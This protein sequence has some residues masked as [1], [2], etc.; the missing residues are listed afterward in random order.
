MDFFWLYFAEI[1]NKE[2][3]LLMSTRHFALLGHVITFYDLFIPSKTKFF[4]GDL[5][6]Y[7]QEV[8]KSFQ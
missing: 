3:E 6:Y 4:N 5:I 8:I 7:H 1:K 2:S